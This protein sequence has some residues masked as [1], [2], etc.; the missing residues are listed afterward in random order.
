MKRVFNL[1]FACYLLASSS[2][3]AQDLQLPRDSEKLIVRAQRFWSSLTSGQRLQA[4]EFVLPEKKNSFLSGTPLPILQAKVQGVDLTTDPGQAIVRVS[5][6]VLGVAATSGELNWTIADPWVWRGG[7][8]Y[9]NLESL[10]DLY[11]KGGALE[12]INVK[13]VQQSID[14]SFQ[15]LRNPIDLGR[16]TDGQH[17][18][19]DVPIQYTGDLPL[20]VELAISNP[21]VSLP[22]M[23]PITS[24][25]KNLVL[26]VGT[27]S[28]EGPFELPLHLRIRYR[29]AAVERTLMLKGEVF[30]PIAFRQDPPNGP[31]E[32][33]REFSVFIRNNTGQEAGIRF[34]STDAKLDIMKQ[35]QTLLPNQEAEVVFKLRRNQSPDNLYLQLDGPLNGREIYT[36]RFRNSRP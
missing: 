25:S 19:T 29:E 22:V 5:L 24:L 34:I 8:W 26:L 2:I 27:D 15:I 35:P 32:E 13:E 11:A 23:D 3:L 21:L 28:W 7:N 1:A 14:T 33:G 18:S 36:Y 10:A 30:V 31:I 17:F 20:S 6:N 4:L 9:L 12:K 16:L